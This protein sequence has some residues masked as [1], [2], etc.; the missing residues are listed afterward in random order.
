[1][2]ILDL[3]MQV[4]VPIHIAKTLTYPERVIPSNIELMRKLVRNGPDIHPG[5]N[6]VQ[7]KSSQNRRYLKYGD[8]NKVAQELEVQSV[9]LHNMILS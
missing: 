4:G 1:M 2:I 9:L 6:Y 5:A 8:R 7:Y 3:F